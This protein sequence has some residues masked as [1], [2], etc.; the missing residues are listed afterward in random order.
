MSYGD[1]NEQSAYPAAS[2]DGDTVV[3]VLS[4]YKNKKKWDNVYLLLQ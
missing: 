4:T 1:N 2:A 3:V